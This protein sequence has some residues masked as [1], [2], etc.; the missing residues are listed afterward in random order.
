ME[1]KFI[2]DKIKDCGDATSLYDMLFPEGA[3]VRDFVDW[4]L[5]NSRRERGTL[6]IE[7]LGIE[8]E[9]DNGRGG[10]FNSSVLDKKID[11]IKANGG[12]GMMNYF[13]YVE[14]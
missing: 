5:T 2:F 10:Q 9:Y 4:V 3:T 14:E 6:Y 8:L 1:S 11:H 7:N 13:I 12:W